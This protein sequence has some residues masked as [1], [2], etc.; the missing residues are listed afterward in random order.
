MEPF[1]HMA[2]TQCS[3]MGLALQLHQFIGGVYAYDCLLVLN[4]FHL[5]PPTTVAKV[6]KAGFKRQKGMN[7][8]SSLCV[9]QSQKIERK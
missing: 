3:F 9:N 5:S 8:S 6:N 7:E 2:P 1:F 4:I